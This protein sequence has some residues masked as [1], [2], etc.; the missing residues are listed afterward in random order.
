MQWTQRQQQAIEDRGNNLLVAA[1]AGSGKTAVLIERIKRL[2]ISE[3]IDV[4]QLLVV[5]FTKAAAAEMKEKLIKAIQKEIV[6]GGDNAIF[7]RQQLSRMYKTNISTFHSFAFQVIRKYFYLLDIDPQVRIADEAEAKLLKN[8]AMAEVFDDLYEKEDTAFLNFLKAYAPDKS[9]DSL[10]SRLIRAYDRLMAMT[11]PKEW[12]ET[13]LGNLKS[14]KLEDIHGLSSFIKSES[15]RSIQQA[16]ISYTKIMN[17]FHEYQLEDLASKVEPEWAAVKKIEETLSGSMGETK[18]A[19][20]QYKQTLVRLTAKGDEKEVYKDIKDQVKFHREKAK[21]LIKELEK[22]FYAL[23]EKVYMQDLADTAAQLKEMQQI[24]EL[25]YEKYKEKKAEKNLVDFSDEE[26]YCLQILQDETAA[27]EYR[28]KFHY[29]FIDEYQDSNYLQEEIIHRICRKDNVFMV[30]DIKQCIYRF[31]LAEPDIFWDVYQ[32][33][34]NN[35]KQ[36]GRETGQ[37][38][39]RIDLSTNFRS[40]PWII[41]AV[42]GIFRPIMEGYDDK[43]ALVAGQTETKGTSYPVELI[44]VD[45]DLI[46]EE[47]TQEEAPKTESVLEELEDLSTAELEAVVARK[48]IQSLL[49]KTFYDSKEDVLRPIEKKDI[50]ILMRSVKSTAHIF[51]MALQEVGIDTVTDANGGYFSTGEIAQFLDFLYI[52]DNSRKDLSL[53]SVLRSCAFTFTTDDLIQIRLFHREDAYGDAL[54]DYCESGPNEELKEKCLD[55][56]ETLEKWRKASRAL[57]L[58]IFIWRLMQETGYYAFMGALADG[59]QR[60][61]NL[62]SLVDRASAFCENNGGNL[63][64]FLQYAA[65]MSDAEDAQASEMDDQKDAVRIMTIHK[66]KGLEFPVVLVAGLGR[67]FRF[68]NDDSQFSIHKDLG[69]GTSKVDIQQH[70]HRSTLMQKAIAR[71]AKAEFME[72]E[73]RILY[74]ALTRAKDVLI[75]MGAGT[76][77]ENKIYRCETGTASQGCYLDIIYAQAKE[78]GIAITHENRRTLAEDMILHE[79]KQKEITQSIFEESPRW[80]QWISKEENRQLYEALDKKLTFTYPHAGQME[81]RS[82]Y[83]VSRLNQINGEPLPSLV[84][85][86][87]LSQPEDFTAMHRGTLIHTAMEQIDFAMAKK[88]GLAYIKKRIEQLV[89]EQIFL[90]GEA[91]QIN[92]QQIQKFFA[93]DIGKRAAMARVRKET[94]FNMMM[95]YQGRDILVQGII[96]CWFEDEKGLVLLDYKTNRNTENIRETYRVQMD[97]YKKALEESTGRKVT[98]A[99][100]Y[101]FTTGEFVEM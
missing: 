41:D 21:E 9:D 54:A 68:A 55:F 63:Y 17:L 39:K 62:R 93:T 89:Q 28:E 6:A 29:I 83:S 92:I 80:Q 99:Y 87:F 20:N 76:A 1:A 88:E 67:Q 50:V 11:A 65:Q 58:D 45:A 81:T 30:G 86:S 84:V 95:P 78:M 51:Q 24:L 18:K 4:D 72:E 73:K 82:K 97:I 37:E 49:G 96:D 5:T 66:S 60:Q 19:I 47:E 44:T 25:F 12:L 42:N 10:Q 57:P 94:P 85:P 46:Q 3:N 23:P 74:V 27:A 31:R 38:G 69:I 7:M 77:M 79:E 16:H 64:G 75:M 14:S 32:K 26:Q 13:A 59:I 40:K 100:L 53:L 35:E 36:E 22:D 70:W 33:Y 61:V 98:E 8:E 43:A 56:M 48:K 52:I 90:S 101:L 91:S 15:Q 71:K 34:G 2:I